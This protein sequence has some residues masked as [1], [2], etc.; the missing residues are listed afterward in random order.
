VSF[1]E[2]FELGE[3]DTFV[4]NHG[5]TVATQ[6]IMIPEGEG[7]V[8]EVG[9]SAKGPVQWFNRVRKGKQIELSRSDCDALTVVIK[10]I[11]L[12]W[13]KELTMDQLDKMGLGAEAL[14][15]R[16]VIGAVAGRCEE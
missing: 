14:I 8:A 2:E 5:V 16:K 13:P 9:A 12:T 11:Q 6:F 10:D 15:T 3:R 7:L 4:S 1:R